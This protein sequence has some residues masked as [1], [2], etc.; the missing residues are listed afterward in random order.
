MYLKPALRQC[1]VAPHLFCLGTTCV[2]INMWRPK[3][4]DLMSEVS[5]FFIGG[6][7]EL[8]N[9]SYIKDGGQNDGKLNR[10]Y[11]KTVNTGNVVLKLNTLFHTR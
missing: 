2:Q 7:P 1:L 9:L 3:G 8:E 6:K 5:R 10:F 4:D 11:F